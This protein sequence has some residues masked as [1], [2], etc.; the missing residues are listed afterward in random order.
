MRA[1]RHSHLPLDQLD[2]E[3]HVVVFHGS[4]RRARELSLVLD[5]MALAY[6]VVSAPRSAMLVVMPAD[7]GKARELLD[8]YA[9]ES[10][11]WP[12]KEE[13]LP[14]LPGGIPSVVTYGLL[15]LLFRH[16]QLRRIGGLDWWEQGRT[17]A[18]LITASG[19]WWR[20]VTALCLHADLRHLVGNLVFG[21][22]FVLFLAQLHGPGW[23]WTLV[24]LSGALGNLTNAWVQPVSHSSIG[25]STAVF[26]ALGL[27]VADAWRWRH[28]RLGWMR[29]LAPFVVGVALL[30]YLG[31]AGER[32]DVMAHVTG[33]AWGIV[34]GTLFGTIERRLPHGGRAQVLAGL[35]TLAVIAAAWGWGLSVAG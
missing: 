29:R 16:L 20:V 35:A 11:D 6:E 33:F 7:S 31:T 5:A 28:R 3:Q 23:A 32:T 4:M 2:P 22:M 9:E 17:Q 14:S 12:P 27:L 24:L 25:A 21:S 1:D 10:R 26:G 30:G 19:E 34:V 18:D 13:P 8:S 15:L